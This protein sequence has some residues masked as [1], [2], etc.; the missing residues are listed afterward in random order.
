MGTTEYTELNDVISESP[1][2]KN[3]LIKEYDQ[4]AY[5]VGVMAR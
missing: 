2:L 1:E 4:W 5:R 3:Q